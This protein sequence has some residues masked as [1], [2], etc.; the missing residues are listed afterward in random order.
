MQQGDHAIEGEVNSII[1]NPITS[2]ILKWWRFEHLRWIQ[3]LHHLAVDYQ[4]LSL[5]TM[6]TVP[7]L[8][9]S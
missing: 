9:G 2:T 7:L 5:V 3:N 4:G 8:C 6:V 1:F